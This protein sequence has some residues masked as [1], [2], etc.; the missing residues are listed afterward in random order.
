MNFSFDN[1]VWGQQ[2]IAI[3]V[4]EGPDG[5]NRELPFVIG[6]LADLSGAPN[7]PLPRLRDRRFARVTLANFD[8]M[9]AARAPHLTLAVA[10]KLV[11]D[12]G[13]SQLKVDFAFRELNDFSPE[14]VTRQIKPL[15][16]LLDLREKLAGLRNAL[17]AKDGLDDMLQEAVCSSDKLEQLKAEIDSKPPNLPSP[18]GPPPPARS[19]VPPPERGVWSRAKHTDDPSLLDQL[20]DAFP[21][22]GPHQREATRDSLKEFF[23]QVISGDMAAGLEAETRINFRIAQIDHLI[24]LQ[25]REV[26]HHPDFMRLEASWRGLHFLV[27]RTRKSE[28]VEIHVL[29]I[30]KKELLLQFVRE[31][32]RYGSPL[33]RKIM[34]QAAGTPGKTPFSLLISD[35]AIGSSPDDSEIMARMARLGA[36]A[37]LPFITSADPDLLGFSS[38]TQILD[39]AL[40]DRT[41][42]AVRYTKWNSFRARLESR[43]VGLVLPRM[44]LRAPYCRETGLPGQFNFEEGIDNDTDSSSLLW[45]SVAWAFAAQQA[46]DFDRYGWFGVTRTP[47]DPGELT[48]LLAFCF[49]TEDGDLS[50]IGPAEMPVSDKRYLELRSMGLIPICQVAATDRAAFFEAWSCHLPKI[51]P[52]DDPPTT[53][54]SA[55]IDCVLAVSRIAHYLRHILQTERRRFSSVRD[56]EEYLQ[57]WIAPY[58]VPYYAQETRFESAFPLLNARLGVE[59]ASEP[60]RPSVLRAWLTPRRAVGVLAHPVEIVIPVALPWALALSSAPQN[61]GL[62]QMTPPSTLLATAMPYSNGFI[63]GREHF[64]RRALMAE[65]CVASRKLDVAILILEE[66]AGQIDRYH[67]DEWESPQLITQVW[68]LLRRCYLLTANT[69]VSDDRPVTLLRKICRLDPFRALE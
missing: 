68:D 61:S 44:L 14:A 18:P 17:Q 64:I 62:L 12:D 11:E 23:A 66:L 48:N 35:F 60:S 41:F 67:L 39:A 42:D 58:V 26:L 51:D 31:R 4:K 38:F 54:E 19:E 3:T 21:V 2:R 43:Y 46:A 65:A 69:S 28:D 36:A 63:S 57:R 53:Y 33:G 56:C 49:R 25:L 32:E 1:S 59:L 20:T 7:K 52:D 16:E 5:T 30:T 22:S 47:D 34:D 40:L 55:E 27:S 9:L 24:S 15:K 29:N 45:G 6:V 13:Y 50:W 10:N 37:H 8:Q